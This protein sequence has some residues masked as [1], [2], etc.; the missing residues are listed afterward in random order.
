MLSCK[1]ATRL[2]SEKLDRKLPFWQRLSLHLHVL[3]CRACSRYA[4]Q[5]TILDRI[6]AEHYGSD[7]TI[8]EPECLPN[9][10]LERIKASLRAVKP[11]TDSPDAK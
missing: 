5:V 6:V 4:R 10:S 7:P 8:V 1:E 11:D 9:N 3:M 2:V